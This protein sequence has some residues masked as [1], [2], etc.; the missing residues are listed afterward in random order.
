[1]TPTIGGRAIFRVGES[2]PTTFKAT[3]HQEDHQSSSAGGHDDR[4][5]YR[6]GEYGYRKNNN[7][8][9]RT[10]GLLLTHSPTNASTSSTSTANTNTSISISVPSI[11]ISSS[12]STSNGN[13]NSNSD[14]AH[15]ER[16]PKHQHS[17]S[18]VSL[19]EP[20]SNDRP[21]AI[22]AQARQ[23]N[24]TP[25]STSSPSPSPLPSFS[26]AI[27]GSGTGTGTALLSRAVAGPLG[28]GLGTSSGAGANNTTTSTTRLTGVTGVP[29]TIP[30]VDQCTIRPERVSYGFLVPL[31]VTSCTLLV[32]PS[33]HLFSTMR[34]V[35]YYLPRYLRGMSLL[36]YWYGTRTAYRS[37][38]R[39]YPFELPAIVVFLFPVSN[40][41]LS[42]IF[43]STCNFLGPY[44]GPQ[45]L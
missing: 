43:L 3:A 18:S 6:Y 21:E 41:F 33:T 9:N 32:F 28:P 25:T 38:P 40:P 23:Q 1:M 20:V 5:P 30:T 14:S 22:Q 16:T 29:G 35:R 13:S 17:S 42:L 27:A 8:T 15:Q 36:R 24:A 31:P 12:S 4:Y 44:L 11:T 2:D 7:Q 39:L 34:P 19:P 26:P 37:L 10:D 45:F